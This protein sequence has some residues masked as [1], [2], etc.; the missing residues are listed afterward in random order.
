[1]KAPK[2]LPW[3]ARKAGLN[4]EAALNLWRRATGE[5]EK[6]CGSR[7][8]ADYY[9]AALQRFIA[10]IEGESSVPVAQPTLH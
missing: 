5:S 3:M 6:L 1:M 7:E 10:L 2:L 4:D 8:S 9:S